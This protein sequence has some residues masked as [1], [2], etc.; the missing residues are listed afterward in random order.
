MG[1][2][3]DHN[4]DDPLEQFPRLC[5]CGIYTRQSRNSDSEFS[6]CEAQFD[7]CF[8]FVRSR[9]EEGWVWNGQCYDDPAESSETLQR[10]AMER[11]LN[12]VRQGTIGRVVVHRLDRLSRKI[13]DC[14]SFLQEL[15]ERE[16]PLTIV[17]QP[18]LGITAGDAFILNLMASFAE[19]EQEL[20]RSRLAEA[21]AAHKRRGRRVAGVVPYGYQADP[22]TRQLI[23]VER[24]ARCVRSMFQLAA[25]GKTPREIAEI[26]N[27]Q[28]WRKQTRNDCDPNGWTPRQVLAVLTNPVHAG[29]IRDGGESRPG[30]HEAIVDRE[31][32]EQVQTQIR[33]RR[34]R[35]PGWS[36]ATLRW[37]LRGL[38]RCGQ[39][40]RVMSPSVSGHGNLRYQYYRCR[41]HAG[42]K[43]PCR[44]VSLPALEIESYVI[45]LLGSDDLETDAESAHQ[46]E[47]VRQFR[48]SWSSLDE[49]ARN[50]LLPGVVQEVVFDPHSST[51]SVAFHEQALERLQNQSQSCGASER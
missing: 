29:L 4:G 5:W 14:T 20:I 30:A 46:M 34:T 33:S 35:P 12:D 32:F 26:A 2:S 11:L 37:P 16:V 6:S 19:F 15:R 50:D 48:T 51:V 25:K 23:V 1:T 3:A 28:D 22:I 40:G 44:G 27:Q 42:G 41:S 36:E 39:C 7:T 8:G 31:L 9:I 18:E 38:L 49:R 47:Q 10:P 43:P 13:A 17:A 45:E 21:R 24:E